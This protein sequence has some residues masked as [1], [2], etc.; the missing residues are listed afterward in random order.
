MFRF[1]SQS[2]GISAAPKIQQGLPDIDQLF[3]VGTISNTPFSSGVNN[4]TSNKITIG[5]NAM[6]SAPV[7]AGSVRYGDMSTAVV[8]GQSS[9]RTTSTEVPSASSSAKLVSTTSAVSAAVASE[10]AA[11]AWDDDTELDALIDAD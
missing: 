9:Q 5:S 1:G 4:S 10:E 2:I 3:G 8:S 7:S 6:K 11:D